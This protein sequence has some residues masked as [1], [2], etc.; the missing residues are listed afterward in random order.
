M[1]FI[2]I[3]K[4]ELVERLAADGMSDEQARDF[5]TLCTFLGA[6]YHHD[7]YDELV[8][9]KESFGRFNDV[10]LNREAEDDAADFDNLMS[11]FTGVLQRGN[12]VELTKEEIEHLG[13][14][15][16]LL[17]VKTR[18]P[19][20][21][22][23]TVRIFY[24]GL[25]TETVTQ[26]KALSTRQVTQDIFGDV[27]VF[28]R[29]RKADNGK[30]RR[31]I[32]SRPTKLPDGIHPGT[33]MIKSFR[34]I[35]RSEL[36]MLLPD[37][38]VVMSSWDALFIGGPA[39]IGGIPIALNIIPALSVV[40]VVL[41]A[42]LGFSGSVS[43]DKLM[44][45]VGSLSALVGAGAFLFRQYTNYAFRKL[46]YQKKVSDNVYFRN[47]NNDTGVFDTLI[48]SAEEQEVKEVILA[49]HSLFAHGPVP[50]TGELDRR[51]EGWLQEKFGLDVDFEVGDALDKL[52]GLGFLAQK[53]RK[54]AVCPL[55]EALSR[56]DR[57]WDRLYD[58]SAAAGG[59]SLKIAGGTGHS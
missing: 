26:K 44:Q 15:H 8:E 40:L 59:A 50:H 53:D 4:S 27:V 34:N 33:L 17:D 16:P 19:M 43:Q 3:R 9:M 14:E 51:I 5:R 32:I 42:Y 23:D 13:G 35:A 2:P 48:G 45:A 38:K 57:L 29:F 41:G 49:Y 30:G 21:I 46:K 55:N 28:V 54:I 11:T 10:I 18:A 25:R 47:V 58:F 22:Y 52:E 12:F 31:R 37:V 24:R 1:Q 7:F 39:I 6:Y 56:L 36:P 20:D